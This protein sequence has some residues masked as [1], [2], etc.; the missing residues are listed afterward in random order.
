MN[1]FAKLTI[2][3]F[4]LLL[5]SPL[6][7]FAQYIPKPSPNFSSSGQMKFNMVKPK[8]LE[9]F[10]G[11]IQQ[12][13]D[14]SGL[15]DP[16]GEFETHQMYEERQRRASMYKVSIHEK[17]QRKY[18]TY[19]KEQDNARKNKIRNSLEKVT[20]ALEGIG[21]YE[22]DRGQYFPVKING[23]WDNLHVP[24]SDAPS[25][26]ENFKGAKA[27]ADRQLKEDGETYE[28]FNITV[29]HPIT[30]APYLFGPQREPL[31]LSH[32]ALEPSEKDEGIPR[33]EA[34]VQFIDPSGNSLLDAREKAQL[35]I[36]INNLGKGEAK[37]IFA[38]IE[39]GEINALIVKRPLPIES[40]APGKS[41]KMTIG[42]EAGERIKSAE[43]AFLISF[44]EERFF[45]PPPQNVTIEVQ[46]LKPPA[47]ALGTL[48]IEEK[49]GNQNNVIE[50][51]ELIKVTTFLRNTG[52][53]SAENVTVN[54]LIDD[55]NIFP[56]EKKSYPLSR[57]IPSIGVDEQ[58]IFEFVFAV[59]FKYKGGDILPIHLEVA[60]GFNAVPKNIPLN[61]RLKEKLLSVKDIKI[62]G[63]YGDIGNR[64]D[65]ALVFCVSDYQNEG[66]T[67]LANPVKDGQAIAQEL[68]AHYGFEVELLSNPTL[69][70]MVNKIREYQDNFS[71]NKD[72]R[73]HPASQLFI[74]LSGHGE[75]EN[76]VGYFLPS[77]ADNRELYRTAFSYDIWRRN[78]DQI[79][80]NHIMVAI[81][82]CYSGYF[83]ADPNFR[84]GGNKDRFGRP[85]ELME[86]EKILQDHLKLKTRLYLTSSSD[87]KTPDKSNFAKNILA[88]LR[89]RN[90]PN[91]ILN[92][93][94]IHA[95]YL[96]QVRPRPLIGEFGQDEGGST[97]LFIEKEQ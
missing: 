3:L 67:P 51:G 82:A 80:C 19:L 31:Y 15:F 33:L 50:N 65:Y 56:V 85:N 81:D 1:P 63:V 23:G 11:Q 27:T 9:L 17:Y 18:K 89:T 64:K 58:V 36:T 25:F 39:H 70:Q 76:E 73:F 87:E 6:L 93:R 20:L 38:Q 22:P 48:G 55:E 26:K 96:D 42:L 54:V 49:E 41:G 30:N 34:S 21:K 52:E 53:L 94:A 95:N 97:F 5:H 35:E 92:A 88:A 77:D 12:E 91:G 46:G 61:L 16:K 79:N 84:S 62:E 2:S 69:E 47:L 83:K 78:I 86:R 44:T 14:E 29:Y 24:L 72:N 40:I 45:P 7:L 59:N 43:I 32:I 13:M 71:V 68:R 8:Y 37:N 57:T 75:V 28:V 10:G 66:L 60:D 90:H 4:L 74:Y